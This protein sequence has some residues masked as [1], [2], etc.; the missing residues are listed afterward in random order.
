MS[1]G[2]GPLILILAT[3]W[4]WVKYSQWNIYSSLSSST[5]FSWCGAAYIQR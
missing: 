5:A 1:G 3:R 2:I 4:R